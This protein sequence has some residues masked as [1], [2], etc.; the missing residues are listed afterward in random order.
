MHSAE[1]SA[2][3]REKR[4]SVGRKESPGGVLWTRIN[5]RGWRGRLC[6]KMNDCREVVKSFIQIARGWLLDQAIC[7]ACWKSRLASRT[8]CV[9]PELR[10]RRKRD[11]ED[12]EILVQTK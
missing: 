10:R 3:V 7:H 6:W 1:N 9:M 5:E 12:K 2:E 4:R 8:C 11:A